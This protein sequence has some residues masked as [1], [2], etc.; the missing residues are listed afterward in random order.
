MER[1]LPIFVFFCGLHLDLKQLA[2]FK[3]FFFFKSPALEI[4]AF[5]FLDAGVRASAKMMTFSAFTS[6]SFWL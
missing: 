2:L 6:D 5:V 4:P 1:H 3:F